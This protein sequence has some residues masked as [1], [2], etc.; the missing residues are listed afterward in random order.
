MCATPHPDVFWY[1]LNSMGTQK[2][3]PKKVLVLFFP[4]IFHVKTKWNIVYEYL[5]T[6]IFSGDTNILP[7]MHWTSNIFGYSATTIRGFW[8]SLNYP[9][10][11]FKKTV[12]PKNVRMWH[13]CVSIFHNFLASTKQEKFITKIFFFIQYWMKI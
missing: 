12:S 1:Y 2:N 7:Q 8:V 3:A 4:Y 11:N 5:K 9:I 10:L 13:W 6:K